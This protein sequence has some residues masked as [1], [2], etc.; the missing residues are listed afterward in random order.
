MDMA[1]MGNLLGSFPSSVLLGLAVLPLLGLIFQWRL[2]LRAE[3]RRKAAELLRISN[4]H[5]FTTT[6]SKSRDPRQMAEETLDLILQTLGLSTGCVVLQA[7]GPEELDC[8][9]ARGFTQ[10]AA[11]RLSRGALGDYTASC[12]ERWGNL[13]VFPDLRQLPLPGA[14][15]RDALFMELR[16][17]LTEEGLGTLLVAGLQVKTS[18]YG[19]ILA[20]SRGLRTFQPQELRL[21]IAVNN[22]LSVALENHLLHRAAERH[23]EEL[24]ILHRIGEALCATFDLEKQLQIL[25]SELKGLLGASNFSLAFQ[26]SP[27]ARLE[28][29]VA[30]EEGPAESPLRLPRTDELS[31]HVLT[32]RAPLLINKNFVVTAHQLGISVADPRIR[33]WGGVP[34]NFSDGSMGV[35]AVA[36]FERE[37]AIDERQFGLLRVLANETAAAIENA[38]L[39]RQEQRRARHLALLNELGRKAAEVLHPQE[40]LTN[41]CQQVRQAFG[42]DLVR[43]EVMDRQRDELV[44]EAEAGYGSGLLGRRVRLGEGLAGAAAKQGEPV[45]IHNLVQDP[46]YVAVHPAVRSALSLPLDYR[47]EILGVLSI[48]SLREQSFTDQDVLTLRALA[49]Q[50]AVALHNARAYQVAL[51]QAITDGL[52]GLKTHRFF[53]ESLEA[54]CRRA[55][56]SGRLFSLI[57]LDLDGFKAVNDRHGHQEG[58]RVLGAVACLLEARSRQSN[59]VARYGGD[60]FAIL[61]PEATTEQAEVVAER[62][63]AMFEADSYLASHRITASFGIASFPMHGPTPD[64][65]LRVADSEMY[66]AKHQKGNCVRTASLVAQ[67][68]G[69]EWEQQLLEAYL[70]VAMKRL[71]STGPE[72]FNQY[73]RRFE[74][75][76]NQGNGESVALLDT[77]TAL[78]F[79]IDAKDHYTQGH[80]QAVG[81]L[82]AQ[83]ARHIGWDNSQVE[84]IRLAGILHDIGK[85]GVPEALLNKPARLTLDEYEIVKTH[86][87]LGGKILEPLKV[88]SIERI[89]SLVRH[90]HECFDGKGYPDQLG[91]N[92]IPLGA[93]ILTIAD[94]YDTIVSDRTYKKGRTIEDAIAELH[95]CS[96]SQFDGELVEAFLKTL[97]DPGLTRPV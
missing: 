13:M 87:P 11:A 48:E 96:G 3:K 54:E 90:H 45:V 15:P 59:V 14:W 9:V 81:H 27:G 79:A 89:R 20:G 4:L 83:I 46:R 76:M 16:D 65:I 31:K 85:I 22:Q 71:F 17:V 50:L 41:I 29:V 2:H 7:R 58:D 5:Q 84:E 36:D 34:L 49:G 66:L 12:A 86:A 70:G 61:M 68:P 69:S 47:G 6:L 97:N 91:G 56:R 37:R 23:N 30:F 62:L 38:R 82:G 28:T 74:Q 92:D 73:L 10:S 77:V 33:T 88:K 78:A 93:R 95:R 39:F 63:R 32:T 60:E 25:R 40:L 72:A 44:V 26:D 8:Y 57:M 67:T 18:S 24:K 51:E 42:Y 55:T 52:T 35:L 94:A 64:E 80:S 21:I 75:A 1:P 53:M 19:V 43:V